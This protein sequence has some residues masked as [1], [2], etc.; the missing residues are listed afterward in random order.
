[1]TQKPVSASHDSPDGPEAMTAEWLTTVLRWS[2]AVAEAAVTSFTWE[3]LG[4]EGWTTRMARVTLAYD[5]AADGA[6]A[7]LIAKFSAQDAGTRAFFG[8]FYEREVFFYR[9]IAPYVPLRVPYCYHADYDSSTL[10]HVLLLEDMAPA[11]AGDWISGISVDVAMEYT[12]RMAVLH[13]Q[14]W[15]SPRLVALLARYPV[16]GATFAQG[17]AER[18][19]GGISVMRPYLDTATCAL[20]KRLQR[21]LQERWRRQSTGPQTLIHWDAH[22]A[23]LLLPSINGGV[24]AVVDWQNWTVGRGIWDVTRFC[25]LSLP[26]AERRAAE[27]DIVALYTKTLATFGVRDYPFANALADYQDAMPL[28]FAQ[29]LRFF[30]SMPHWD[31]ARRA[32]VAAITPRVVA[33]LHDAAAAGLID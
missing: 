1:M 23:N 10:A 15:Q 22:A 19:A 32:W 21:G 16:P 14:Q 31:D 29:Q 13:A 17:Y 9:S 11:A 4:A 7:T 33:A 27:G 24:F 5:R 3:A 12:R 30:G 2:G 18:F 8:R 20:A 6:P 26:V 28:Q 25:I